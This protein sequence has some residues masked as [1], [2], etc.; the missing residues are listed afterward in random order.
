MILT[1]S[2]NKDLSHI[3]VRKYFCLKKEML[4]TH[5]SSRNLAEPK[6]S[7]NQQNTTGR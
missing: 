7:R 3:N 5:E 2:G 1:G 4:K 6:S